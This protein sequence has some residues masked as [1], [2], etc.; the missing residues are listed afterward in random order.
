MKGSGQIMPAKRARTPLAADWF[1]RG[2][3]SGSPKRKKEKQAKIRKTKST[4][5]ATAANKD[6]ALSDA[7]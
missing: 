3:S 5:A 2:A 7:E 1:K 4:S 6:K